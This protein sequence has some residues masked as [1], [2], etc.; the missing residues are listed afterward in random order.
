MLENVGNP[1]G[2]LFVRFLP[3]GRL[4]VFGV[5]QNDGTGGFQNVVNRYPILPCGLHAHIFAVIFRQPCGTPA[6]V[7]GEG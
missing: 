1:L 6:Q 7:I 2:V 5:R 3:S 4:D